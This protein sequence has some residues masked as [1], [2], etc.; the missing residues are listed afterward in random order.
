MPT[1]EECYRRGFKEGVEACVEQAQ[2][3]DLM[4]ELGVHNTHNTHNTHKG[5]ERVTARRAYEKK[6]MKKSPYRK[7]LT[8]Q[9]AIVEKKH[10]RM[11]FGSKATEAHRLTRKKLGI[12][13][14]R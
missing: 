14:K 5:E 8:R 13:K 1:C 9:Q 4:P 10:P 7:E 2:R 11:S 12:R 3:G 6:P